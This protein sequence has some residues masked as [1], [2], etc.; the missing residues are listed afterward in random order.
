MRRLLVL[1]GGY[2]SDPCFIELKP[3]CTGE[4]VLTKLCAVV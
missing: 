1:A 2:C 3:Y 4:S